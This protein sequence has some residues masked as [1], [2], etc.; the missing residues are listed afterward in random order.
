MVVP[1]IEFFLKLDQGDHTD[2]APPFLLHFGVP[3]DRLADG[4]KQGEMI[5]AKVMK[6]REFADD[7]DAAQFAI[8]DAIVNNG[9]M[10][11]QYQQFLGMVLVHLATNTPE[12]LALV[13]SAAKV[14][15]MLAPGDILKLDGIKETAS[16]HGG[17]S[18][19]TLGIHDGGKLFH[20]RF[21]S[22]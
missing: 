19:G 14:G 20:F 1:V 2:V 6:A 12:K 8:A 10:E 15:Y 13:E 22:V 9:H 5:V 11:P 21:V 4:R 18:V 3:R 7:T 16:E 17:G